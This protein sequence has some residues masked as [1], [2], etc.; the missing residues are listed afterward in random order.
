MRRR[1]LESETRASLRALAN[2]F[3]TRDLP[4]GRL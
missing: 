4:E 1:Q 2:H 3:S